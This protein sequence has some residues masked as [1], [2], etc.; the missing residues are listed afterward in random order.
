MNRLFKSALFPILV[1]LVLAFFALKIVNSSSSGPSVTWTSLVDATNS[2]R[3]ETIKTDLGGKCLTYKLTNG[4]TNSVGIPSS[5]LLNAELAA[6]KH[7]GVSSVDGSKTGGSPWWSALMASQSACTDG[8]S[9]WYSVRSLSTSTICGSFVSGC[10]MAPATSASGSSR[11]TWAS[12]DARSSRTSLPVSVPA[13]LMAS[14]EF[15]SP[16]NASTSLAGASSAVMVSN[17]RQ[18]ASAPS[19]T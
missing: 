18:S 4:K 1:V 3:V 14:R 11:S 7:K 19:S 9:T 17:V 15:P 12:P 10:S 2:G 5:A 6:A 8:S 13:E 16:V